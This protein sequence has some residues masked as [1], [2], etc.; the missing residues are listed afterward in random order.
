MIVVAVIGVIASIAIPYYQKMSA[1]SYRSEMLTSLANFRL[2]FKNVYDNS[3]NFATN[4]PVAPGMTSDVNPPV[5]SLYPIGQPE[6]WSSAAKGW[7]DLPFPPEG[8]IRM[9]YW[10]TMGALD[11]ASG[12]QTIV[13][14]VCGSF[15]GFGQNTVSCAQ[16]IHGNY[17]YTE[18]FYSNGAS[19]PPVELPANA[20]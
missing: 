8:G 12:I 20:F 2:Y 15:P 3:G 9:R 5:N 11:P 1:R 10:Y 16:G 17:L 18:T 6:A 4:N 19:D 13:F 14:S 7:S